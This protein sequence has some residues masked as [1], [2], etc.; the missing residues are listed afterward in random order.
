MREGTKA[1]LGL[2]EVTGTLLFVYKLSVKKKVFVVTRLYCCMKL[3][4]VFCCVQ[5]DLLPE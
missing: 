1:M 4:F 5:V 3:P 2:H